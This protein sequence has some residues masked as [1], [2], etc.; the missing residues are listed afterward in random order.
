MLVSIPIKYMHTPVELVSMDDINN[1]GKIIAKL[2]ENL[3]SD[4]LEELLCF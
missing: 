1:T 4:D 3:K 2:I